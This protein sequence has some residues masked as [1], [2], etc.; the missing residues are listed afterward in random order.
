MVSVAVVVVAMMRSFP[1]MR[2]GLKAA[3]VRGS[4]R[5]DI[6]VTPLA[7]LTQGTPGQVAGTTTTVRVKTPS[8]GSSPEAGMRARRLRTRL[9][10][11]VVTGPSRAT[12]DPDQ[13]PDANG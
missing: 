7:L 10:G 12:T 11:T 6:I 9:G 13:R 8:A 1:G 2:W 3:P 5:L 4:G